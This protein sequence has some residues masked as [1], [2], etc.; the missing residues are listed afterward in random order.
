MSSLF[1]Q[2]KSSAER[3]IFEKVVTDF[4]FSIIAH[5]KLR[6]ILNFY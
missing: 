1:A 4:F 6:A 3:K 2:F 5:V